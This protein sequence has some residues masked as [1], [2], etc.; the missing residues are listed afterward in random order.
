M[1]IEDNNGS[2]T[3]IKVL[4]P[5]MVHIYKKLQSFFI[6]WRNTSIYISKYLNIGCYK[7]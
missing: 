5:H 1:Y 3:Y 2:A 6:I 7:L 4:Y